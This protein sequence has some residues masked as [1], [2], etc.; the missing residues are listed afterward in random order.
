MTK[1][2]AAEAG[3]GEAG[4]KFFFGEGGPSGVVHAGDLGTVR[5][6]FG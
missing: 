5:L 6:E 2:G 1:A 3:V 4:F